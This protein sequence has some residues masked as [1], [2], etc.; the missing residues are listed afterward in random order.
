LGHLQAA[1]KCHTRCWCTVQRILVSGCCCKGQPWPQQGRSACAQAH[2]GS[3]SLTF[4][5]MVQPAARAGA[6][7]Q[8]AIRMG[9]F[10]R[11]TRQSPHDLY[12]A[13]NGLRLGLLFCL[14][15]T[16]TWRPGAPP[17]G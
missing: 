15:A 8:A 6:S 3:S 5:T 16:T 12:D 10:C 11:F 17:R 4:S 13:S 1:G 7:F 9:K 14:N 2:E